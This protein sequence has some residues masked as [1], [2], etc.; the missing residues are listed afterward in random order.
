ML[1]SNA[2]NVPKER[3]KVKMTAIAVLLK[4]LRSFMETLKYSFTKNSRVFFPAVVIYNRPLTIAA[5]LTNF[6]MNANSHILRD[7]VTQQ[8][9]VSR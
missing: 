7:C 6:T 3:S 2:G 5:K 9:T 4:F 1:K 8:T